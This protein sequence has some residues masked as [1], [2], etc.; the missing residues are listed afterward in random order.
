MEQK[1]TSFEAVPLAVEYFRSKD[2]NFFARRNDKRGKCKRWQ[3][4][5]ENNRLYI[6]V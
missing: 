6:V 3:R 4:F 2:E 5:D 1:F